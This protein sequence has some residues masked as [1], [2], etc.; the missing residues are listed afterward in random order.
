MDK[1]P[2]E[3]QAGFAWR[4]APSVNMSKFDRLTL[5]A[6]QGQPEW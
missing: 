4:G 5:Y 1:Q 6:K 3:A 2:N